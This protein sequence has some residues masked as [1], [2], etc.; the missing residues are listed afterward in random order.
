MT[1]QEVTGTVIEMRCNK[2]SGRS[3]ALV[4]DR[5]SYA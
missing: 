1:T 5:E 2:E 4:K 3:S